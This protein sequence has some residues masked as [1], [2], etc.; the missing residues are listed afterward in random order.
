[1][2]FILSLELIFFET[3]RYMVIFI[4]YEVNKSVRYLLI[5]QRQNLFLFGVSQA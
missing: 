5:K 2:D 3:K 4:R 1:M